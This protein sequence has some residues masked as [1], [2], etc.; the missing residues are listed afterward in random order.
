MDFLHI[1]CHLI[2][3]LMPS[4]INEARGGRKYAENP[5]GEI[6]STVL[7]TEGKEKEVTSCT[8]SLL[9]LVQRQIQR[10]K[11]QHLN[12]SKQISWVS[13]NIYKNKMQQFIW[14]DSAAE[15]GN[16][17]RVQHFLKHFFL[18]SLIFLFL[19]DFADFV[20]KG[21]RVFIYYLMGPLKCCAFVVF[22]ND[23]EEQMKYCQRYNG[24]RGSVLLTKY[25]PNRDTSRLI[26]SFDKYWKL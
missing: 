19:W 12:R 13:K 2:T 7:Q 23:L 20:L 10:N 26:L 8:S 21:V 1:F 16:P 17:H 9:L 6:Y 3:S 24:P 5:W 18:L 14:S 22:L 15:V 25:L 11:R 4:M